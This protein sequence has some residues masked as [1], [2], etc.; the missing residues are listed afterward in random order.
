VNVQPDL[1]SKKI[2]SPELQKI[3]DKILDWRDETHGLVI[4]YAG[5]L[6][7]N[8][9]AFEALSEAVKDSPTP[10]KTLLFGHFTQPQMKILMDTH[11]IFI[12]YTNY[13]N[14]ASFLGNSKPDLLLAPLDQNRTSMSKAPNKYLEYSVVGAAGIY[15]NIHPYTEVIQ[16]GVNGIL[17]EDNVDEWKKAILGLIIHPKQMRKIALTAKKDVIEK[18]STQMISSKFIEAI[19]S[20]VCRN[21]LSIRS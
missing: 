6:R 8:D 13:Q 15:S 3:A 5:S 14:Y 12:P 10:I 7:Y 11:P 17:V 2:T 19:K 4:G 9:V 21:D 1:F 16:S 18:Y 20:V